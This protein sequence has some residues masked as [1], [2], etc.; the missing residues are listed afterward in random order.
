MPS[1]IP[2]DAN[3]ISDRV[4]G[5]GEESPEAAPEGESADASAAS[6]RLASYRRSG[7]SAF[8]NGLQSFRNGSMSDA[9]GSFDSATQADP[10]NA[11]YHYH[12]ALALYNLSNEDAAANALRTAVTIEKKQ[13]VKDWGKRMERVQGRGRL[14]VE[15]ARRDAGLVR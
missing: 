6:Y 3:I 14:W 9:L 15:K 7:D 10:S 13:P 11:L 8:Q 2:S 12:R 4:L 1:G 5:E